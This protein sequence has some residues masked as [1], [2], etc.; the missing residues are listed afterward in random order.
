MKI[1][2]AGAGKGIGKAV[3]ELAHQKGHEVIAVSRS[4]KDLE[5]R[6]YLTIA[7][8][9]ANLDYYQKSTPISGI[10]TVI[11]CTGTHPGLGSVLSISDTGIQSIVNQNILPAMELYRAILPQMREAQKGHFIHVSSGALDF[12]DG[13]EL[14]YCVSKAALEALVLCVQNEDK[15]LGNKILHHAIRV[16]LTDTPLA[17][18][19]CPDITDWNQF[20]TAEETAKLILNIAEKPELYPQVVVPVIP[21]RPIR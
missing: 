21:Y 7:G 5:N 2:I 10:D 18:K 17:R 12:Y 20:Y 1:L 16:S 15:G 4:A 8:D 14:H 3:A 6:D 11:N 9:C 19:V 13:S